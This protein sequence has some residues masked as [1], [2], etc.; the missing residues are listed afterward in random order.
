MKEALTKKE[1]PSVCENKPIGE[2]EEDFEVVLLDGVLGFGLSL[3]NAAL[4]LVEVF[5]LNGDTVFCGSVAVL[6]ALMV[7]LLLRCGQRLTD[8][9]QTSERFQGGRVLVGLHTGGFA[10]AI[11]LMWLG[12][13]NV[14]V[15]CASVGLVA[16]AF[17]YGRFLVALAREALMFV[18]DAVFMYVGA[19][20]LVLSQVGFPYSGIMVSVAVM[21]SIMVAALFIRKR[22]RFSDFVSADDSKARS[23]KV[24]GNNHTL[25]LLGFMFG[26]SSL[27]FLSSSFPRS[28]VVAVVGIAI[29]LAGIVSLMLRQLDERVYKESLKKSMAFASVVLLLPLPLVPEEVR[30]ALLAIYLCFVSLNVIVLLNAVVETSRFDMISPVWLFG[31]EG[32]IFF[33]GIALGG[34]LF[35]LGGFVGE[36]IDTQ[37][38]LYGVC[39]VSV[40]VCAWIQIRVNYQIYPFEP[41]I[42]T[43]LDED[44]C[45]KLEH[46]GK[47]KARWHQ[48]I[49]T[50]CEQYR[51]SPREREVLETLLKG[52]DAKYIMD[53]FFISQSTAK[54]HIYNIY[55]KFGI[56]SR[57]ELLDFIEEIVLPEENGDHA[58]DSEF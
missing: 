6:S 11:A 13:Q 46:E 3:G 19:M 18:I 29:G 20:L 49:D 35:T 9:I 55:R 25:L 8:I 40:A 16:A 14:S 12:W 17:L 7:A 10:A 56:H 1:D 30:L 32:S 52:R 48:K 47:R 38:A 57:Q 24:K 4:M 53:K 37:A 50:A 44:T 33:F 34:A 26:I 28:L 41:V 15:V 5:C 58:Q 42:E 51:L 2:A 23:I 39:I 22:H 27:V 54:T 31:Q 43:R 45:V 21:I 36:T